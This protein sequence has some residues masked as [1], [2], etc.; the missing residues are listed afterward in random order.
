MRTYRRA[1]IALA[2]TLVL[3]LPACSSSSKST[4]ADSAAGTTSAATTPTTLVRPE[5]PAAVLQPL[6]G[7]K[8]IF[9]ASASLLDPNAPKDPGYREDEYSAEGTATSYVAHGDLPTDGT[10]A[11]TTGSSAAY[12]TRIVVRRPTDP[13]KFNG[14]V[15]V[16]WLNVS[17]GLDAAPDYTYLH[18][19]IVR[20]GYAWVGVSA[21]Q[22]GISG[23]AVAVQIPMAESVG[24][25]KG[26]VSIDPARYGSLHHPGDAYSYDIFTQV[27]RSLRAP[28][29]LDV[30]GGLKP[31]HLLA[32]GESQSGFTLTTYADGVQPLTHEFDGFFIHSRGGAAAPLG[33]P[34]AGIDIA[35]SITGKP[36]KIRTDLKVPVMM[37]ETESDVAGVL[38]YLPARQ[39]D[40]DRIRTW[41]IAG[42][43]HVDRYQLG[44][45]GDSFGCSAPINEGPQHFVLAAALRALNTWVLDGTAPPKAE[46]LEV[47]KD[48]KYVED[49][50]GIAR[51]GVRTPPVDVPVDRLSG[52]ADAGGSLACFLAGSTKPLSA[53]QLKAL[54]PSRQDYLDRFA[55]ATD[56]A[57]KAGF[58]LPEDRQ[59]MLDLAQPDRVG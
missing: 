51:G 11:L 34:D 32:V 21:Q 53:A 30:L 12:K 39:D 52:I 6:T 36:T 50:N 49:A 16:E 43:S 41:E 31:A 15:L 27:A 5:G 38:S 42:T 47:G 26:L 59:A 56:A 24:A 45:I 22:I 58:V 19:E 3:A 29:D 37:L 54:Y 14:T 2:A 4:G 10:Y 18:D 7:G 23:G 28:G 46:R 33:K 40:T 57:I 55:K 1:S 25:G 17:G 13:K 48:G 8:G 9:L 20:K 44:A 35:G